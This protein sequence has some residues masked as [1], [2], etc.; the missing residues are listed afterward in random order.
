MNRKIEF[1]A[2]DI[3]N[4]KMIRTYAHIGKDWNMFVAFTQRLQDLYI[5][6]YVWIEDK[7]WKKIYEWDI[8]KKDNDCDWVLWVVWYD[9]Y[10]FVLYEK[11]KLVRDKRQ[12]WRI[13]DMSS[14]IWSVQVYWEVIWNI[15]ENP[16][17]LSSK[18]S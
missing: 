18:E 9:K 5:M 13:F 7:N 12:D 8:I 15:Y 6:Q 17:I 11:E 10:C 1:R 2:W 14:I 4:N 16:D 3:E